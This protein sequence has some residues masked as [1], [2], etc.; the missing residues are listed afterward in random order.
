MRGLT[1]GSGQLTFHRGR[2]FR[3]AVNLGSI[4]DSQTNPGFFVLSCTWLVQLVSVGQTG[5]SPVA[6]LWAGQIRWR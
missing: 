6:T 4:H 1:Y 2:D 5:V 3:T